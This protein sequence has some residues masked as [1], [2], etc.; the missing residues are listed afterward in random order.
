[1]PVDDTVYIL[2]PDAVEIADS[3]RVDA[4]CKLEGG[5]GLQIGD[6]VHVASFCHLNAGGG[7]VTLH[8]HCGLASGVRVVGGMP[9]LAHLHISAAEPP[10][11]CHVI[12]THTTIGPYAVVF[13]NAVICPGVCVGEG[14]VIG[15]GA[16]VTRDVPPYEI[17]AGI[18]AR[19]IGVRNVVDGDDQANYLVGLAGVDREVV[20]A[21]ILE[22]YG[23]AVSDAYA[24]DFVEFVGA[25][26][27]S[28]GA[29]E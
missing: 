17:W 26:S 22:K 8:D 19:C 20:Q 18:P 25:L 27:G 12:R 5:E 6:Y 11:R 29:L 9:D 1:M 4:Y 24:A 7:R 14:A 15:A 2:K 28:A 23:F 13:S 10:D 16:V 21:G 3:A